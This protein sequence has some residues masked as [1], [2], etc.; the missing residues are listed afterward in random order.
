MKRLLILIVLIPCMIPVL[1]AQ[2][3]LKEGIVR[4][5]IDEIYTKTPDVDLMKGSTLSLYF[6][7]EKQKIEL[8]LMQGALRTQ[9]IMDLTTGESVMLADVM[10]QKIRVNQGKE[11]LPELEENIEILYDKNS[12][13]KIEGYDCTKAIVK[14]PYGDKL[15]AYVTSKIK[16]KSNYFDHLFMGIEGFPL[17]FS[18][19]NED[20]VIHFI[21]DEVTGKIDDTV[22]FIFGTYL[23]LSHEEFDTLMGGLQ[24]GF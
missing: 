3:K 5:V 12:T 8:N 4:Y 10:E 18:I 20:I 22:F 11:E 21:A 17:E 9:T 6:S 13:K 14:T 16:P 23:E 1:Q 24:I 19:T 2:K 7:D 15:T